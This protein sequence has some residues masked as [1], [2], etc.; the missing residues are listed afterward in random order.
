MVLL[1]HLVPFEFC[2]GT[3]LGKAHP[4]TWRLASFAGDKGVGSPIAVAVIHC[5]AGIHSAI[6]AKLGD[7]FHTGLQII[8]SVPQF[9]AFTARKFEIGRR[10]PLLVGGLFITEFPIGIQIAIPLQYGVSVFDCISSKIFRCRA[11]F[12]CGEA[13]VVVAPLAEVAIATVGTDIEIIGGV[14]IEAREH[15]IPI[16]CA[17]IDQGIRKFHI[18]DGAVIGIET[19]VRAVRNLVIALSQVARHPLD[20]GFMRIGKIA[21]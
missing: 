9:T 13:G 1:A 14:G 15:V 8:N 19:F 10:N 11:S 6:S 16:R 18:N 5:R 21:A 3:H 2:A 12:L 7:I 20:I 17:C 4:G